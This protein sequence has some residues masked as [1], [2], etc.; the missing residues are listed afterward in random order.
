MSITKYESKEFSIQKYLDIN[1]S[2]RDRNTYPNSSNFV[3]PF[4]NINQKN[5]F[6]AVDPIV[7]GV[8]SA[9]GTTQ[10]GSTSLNEIFLDPNLTPNDIDNFYINQILQVGNDYSTVIGYTGVSHTAITSSNYSSS[11]GGQLYQIRGQKPI[12]IGTATTSGTFSFSISNGSNNN[13]IYQGSYLRVTSGIDSGQIQII[14]Q[15][16]GATKSVTLR[17]SL[18]NP[19]QPGDG[20]EILEFTRDNLQP[21]LYS[22]TDVF[23]QAVCYRVRLLSLS[24]PDLVLTVGYGGTIKNYP[25]LYVKLYSDGDNHS[26][27]TLYSNSIYSKAVTFK[28]PITTSDYTLSQ[29]FIDIRADEE[30]QTIKFKPNSS[31]HFTV[32]LPS[33]EPLVFVLPEFYSPLAPNP[34]VQI[35]A[36]FELERVI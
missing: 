3:I 4:T 25:Y 17:S 20:I 15:Y 29:N 36:L 22:G 31:F 27:Q 7:I 8:P 35:S 33:G 28:V 16:T 23:N 19:I 21:L 11:T 26:H 24:I 6:S 14:T 30:T 1:S 32:T 5:V 9:T 18:T 12:V 34:F 13:N 2:F 10:T